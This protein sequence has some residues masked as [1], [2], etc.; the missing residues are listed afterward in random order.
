MVSR[1]SVEPNLARQSAN[2][3]GR[4]ND[5]VL[6]L[7]K[8]WHFTYVN[9]QAAEL[10]GRRPEDL[11]GRNARTEYPEAEGQQFRRIL[12]EAMAAET[13]IRTETY[14]EPWNRWFE[15]CIYPSPDGVSILIFEISERK[16]AEEAAREDAALLKGQNQVLELIGRGAG[17][18]E[19]LDLLVRTVE[20]E[21]PGMLCSILLLDPDGVHVRYGA[22]PSL[23]E[24]YNRA[25]EGQP[26]GPRAGSCGTAAFRSEPVV[27]E[28][29]ATDPLWEAYRDVALKH[30][31]RACWS[32]PIFDRATARA[33]HLRL[34]FPHSS[35][36]G[37]AASEADRDRHLY[38][39]NRYL[40]TS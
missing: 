2:T 9:R 14:W 21:C 22:A 38:R 24:D 34:L 10:L 26:I 12:E 29:I 13:S 27:V 32:T 11:I 20:A 28:D 3:L 35:P 40:Q 4:V 37:R 23:P 7:D 17:L 33:R 30:G 36:P 19:I 31:L 15:S 39:R 1:E 5:A 8:D 16:Q 25:I 6:A 18:H